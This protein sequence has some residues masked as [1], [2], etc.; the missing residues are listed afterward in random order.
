MSVILKAV[1]SDGEK[2]E[3]CEIETPL[4]SNSLSCLVDALKLIRLKTNSFLS[5]KIALATGTLFF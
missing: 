1:Y 4:V 3:C 5:E 2:A